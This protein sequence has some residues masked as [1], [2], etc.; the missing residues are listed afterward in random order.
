MAGGVSAPQPTVEAPA[1][2]GNAQ[3][4]PTMSPAALPEQPSATA[5]LPDLFWLGQ[6]E[7]LGLLHLEEAGLC[8][9]HSAPR[10][11]RQTPADPALAPGRGKQL[12]PT[13]H[14]LSL[15]Q[16]PNFLLPR[17]RIVLLEGACLNIPFY[18]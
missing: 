10:V 6:R 3:V 9:L 8:K 2:A 13:A 4:H 5:A 16:F 7:P 1:A 17:P 11:T 18:L 14:C 15:L 12:F